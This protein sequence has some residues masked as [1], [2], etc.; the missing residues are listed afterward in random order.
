MNWKE[1]FSLRGISY[2]MV[3]LVTIWTTACDYILLS[4]SY[5]LAEGAEQVIP[6]A[7]L[8]LMGSVF[9]V[10]MI[11]GYLG[12]KIAKDGRGPAYGIYGSLVSVI[13]ILYTILPNLTAIPVAFV[14]LFGGLNGGLFSSRR[15]RRL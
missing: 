1:I 5:Q 11:G 13:M 7:L 14:A 15:R 2:L 6:V 9:L 12:G 8:G 10:A 3:L 4:I